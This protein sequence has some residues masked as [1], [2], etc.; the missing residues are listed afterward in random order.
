MTSARFR[1][2]RSEPGGAGALKE[3]ETAVSD[4]M[5]VLDAVHRIQAEQAPDLAVKELT[6]CVRELG[7]AGIQIGTHVGDRNLDHPSVFPVLE[8][9][10][11]LGAAVFVHPW[12]MLAP[13]RMTSYWLPWLVGMPTET[14]LAICAVIFGGVLDRLPRLRIGFAHGG[15]P[16]RGSSAGLR[17]A[18]TRIGPRPTSM[19]SPL[20]FTSPGKRPWTLS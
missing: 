6:R 11:A 3:Y 2:W 5:V 8:A 19:V 9:A 7:L 18:C 14:A 4:G 20:T 10:E 16:F 13:E 17:T 1:V 12:D 15:G